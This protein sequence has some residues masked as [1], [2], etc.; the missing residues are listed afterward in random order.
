[1]N[2]GEISTNLNVPAAT[3][4]PMK[5]DRESYLKHEQ[6]DKNKQAGHQPKNFCIAKKKK[7]NKVR[8]WSTE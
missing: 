1:M 8:R 6:E 3:W 5:E 4:V 2:E 7:I